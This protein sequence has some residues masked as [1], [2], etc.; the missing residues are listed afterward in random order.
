MN[1]LER[2]GAK[3][4]SQ[5]V[6]PETDRIALYDKYG[7]IAYGIILR[8]V[9]QPDI[10]QRV[11]VEMFA[12]TELRTST[13]ITANP[14]TTIIRIARERALAARPRELQDTPVSADS[15]STKH[16]NLGALIFDLTFCQGCKPELVAEK[17]QITHTD[18]MKAIRDHFAYLRNR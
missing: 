11:L 8:I 6:G 3:S 15:N 12:S 14:A 17:L 7:S 5:G 2:L 16:E 10:A 13:T 4:T 18:V 1:K 9:R